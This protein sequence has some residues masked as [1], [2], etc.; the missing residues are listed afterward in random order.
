GILLL[1]TLEN[2]GERSNYVGQ[3]PAAGAVVV[4]AGMHVATFMYQTPFLTA[5]LGTSGA[6]VLLSVVLEAGPVRHRP[7]I[8]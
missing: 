7:R 6:G 3:S 5:G 2:G 4:P 1:A 8:H